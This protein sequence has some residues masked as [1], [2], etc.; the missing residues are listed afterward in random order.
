[1]VNYWSLNNLMITCTHI[2]FYPNK[3]FCFFWCSLSSPTSLD[4]SQ[5]RPV[6]APKDFLEVIASLKNPNVVDCGDNS[7]WVI[8]VKCQPK[9]GAHRSSFLLQGFLLVGNHPGSSA[10]QGSAPISKDSLSFQHLSAADIHWTDVQ[11]CNV[12]YRYWSEHVY[13]FFLWKSPSP[14]L[15]VA[16][17]ELRPSVAAS[18]AHESSLISSLIHSRHKSQSQGNQRSTFCLFWLQMKAELNEKW[19]QNSIVPLTDPF[20]PL[21]FSLRA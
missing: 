6:Y 18:A 16:S 13:W 3:C 8:K 10:R 19:K 1:M 17:T 9:E 5:F 21:C 15:N 12:I 14:M 4:L 20:F 7:V 2:L 11:P